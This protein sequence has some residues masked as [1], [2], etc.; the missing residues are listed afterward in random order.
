MVPVRFIAEAL[1]G[2]VDWQEEV[3]TAY[4]TY[5]GNLVEVPI[6]SDTIHVN[7]ES[8]TID[9]PSQIID[10]RTM[11]PLRAVAEGLGLDVSFDNNTRTITITQP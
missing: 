10:N 5:N 3:Q 6:Q 8:K 9:T 4:I 7:G 2:T 1:G 11:I